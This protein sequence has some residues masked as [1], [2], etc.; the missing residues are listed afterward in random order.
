MRKVLRYIFRPSTHDPEVVRSI[1]HGLARTSQVIV[2][3]VAAVGLLFL[4]WTFVSPNLFM[5][6][7][8][9]HRSLYAAMLVLLSLW[10]AGMHYAT[11]DYKRHYKMLYSLNATLAVLMYLFVL[12]LC[13]INL[14]FNA[15]VDTTLFMTVALLVPMCLYLNPIE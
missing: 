2:S 3:V 4:V 10:M 5:N 1:F 15:F 9:Y 8:M 7:L 13:Y 14:H 11:K 6:T 12:A